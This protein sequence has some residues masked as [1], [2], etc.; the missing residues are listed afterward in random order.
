MHAQSNGLPEKRPRR[1]KGGRIEAEK[2]AIRAESLN[3][4]PW[5]EFLATGVIKTADRQTGWIAFITSHPG[6]LKTALL[7]CNKATNEVWRL[8]SSERARTIKNI[9]RNIDHDSK[10]PRPRFECKPPTDLS[11]LARDYFTELISNANSESHALTI[12]EA[13][14]ISWGN[15]PDF[16][17][18]S[19]TDVS[20]ANCFHFSSFSDLVEFVSGPLR[21]HFGAGWFTQADAF[22]KHLVSAGKEKSEHRGMITAIAEKTRL[23]PPEMAALA[24]ARLVGFGWLPMNWNNRVAMVGNATADPLSKKARSLRMLF[25]QGIRIFDMPRL[26]FQNMTS[27][28]VTDSS[29]LEDVVDL[30]YTSRNPADRAL[31]TVEFTGYGKREANNVQTESMPPTDEDMLKTGKYFLFRL[32]LNAV[33]V[34]QTLL[35]LVRTTVISYSDAASATGRSAILAGMVRQYEANP[36]TTAL[37]DQIIQEVRSLTYW[38]L[39]RHAVE[40][41]GVNTEGCETQFDLT[42]KIEEWQP[43]HITCGSQSTSPENEPE[44]YL[45]QPVISR[46]ESAGSMASPSTSDASELLDRLFPV[47]TKTDTKQSGASPNRK[48]Q[49]KTRKELAVRD[50]E[51]RKNAGE[52]NSLPLTRKAHFRPVTLFRN[53]LKF[54]HDAKHLHLQV[55]EFL[56]TWIGCLF[57]FVWVMP[58]EPMGPLH[59]TVADPRPREDNLDSQERTT[60]NPAGTFFRSTFAGSA[61]APRVY[62]LLF[63]PATCELA[64]RVDLEPLLR[65]AKIGI[66]KVSAESGPSWLANR[67]TVTRELM[68][69]LGRRIGY[70]ADFEPSYAIGR[71]DGSDSLHRI[72]TSLSSETILRCILLQEGGRDMLRDWSHDLMWRVQALLSRHL[73]DG[74][75]GRKDLKNGKCGVSQNGKPKERQDDELNGTIEQ[76]EIF[77]DPCG[78]ATAALDC[79]RNHLAATMAS[80]RK[81]KQ[82]SLSVY[83]AADRLKRHFRPRISLQSLSTF[84][85][86]DERASVGQ[87]AEAILATNELE[88]LDVQMIKCFKAPDFSKVVDYALA[89]VQLWHQKEGCDHGETPED[90]LAEIAD[91]MFKGPPPKDFVAK[92]DAILKAFHTAARAF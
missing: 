19:N 59:T 84:E 11:G 31:L 49:Y 26:D 21:L 61:L 89:L 65:L 39:P 78:I 50:R 81:G 24:T 17:S 27:L 88:N 8:V 40:L 29:E 5:I 68:D 76:L 48:S 12:P 22:H 10:S 57:R 63:S 4:T 41:P 73:V 91:E 33:S 43:D 42:R 6:L 64:C 77:E 62:P 18:T 67:I 72:L 32:P 2:N 38:S 71:P 46:A 90:F 37:R 14:V 82:T 15:N 55:P 69:E 87:I 51:V 45:V 34:I 92:R 9:L 7:R 70:I 35:P 23:S 86:D 20:R 52:L 80:E 25:D 1:P 47:G 28:N 36:K 13:W 54:I 56:Q 30:Y 74:Q 85:Y 66:D 60:D 83:L 75:G 79:C 44:Q 3:L 16:G 53:F 58:L